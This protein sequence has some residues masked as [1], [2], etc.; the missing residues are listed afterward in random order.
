MSISELPIA[1][2][3]PAGPPVEAPRLPRIHAR[4]NRVFL[5]EPGPSDAARE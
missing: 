4:P 2:T 3:W 5:G 1:A